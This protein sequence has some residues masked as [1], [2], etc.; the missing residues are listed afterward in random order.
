MKRLLLLSA[1]ALTLTGCMGS[2]Q[3]RSNATALS[4][5]ATIQ[6]ASDSQPTQTDLAMSCREIDGE[7][8]R[9][10]ARSE[11]LERTARAQERKG[12]LARGA[13]STGLAALTFGGITNAG[14]VSEIQN[15][16]TAST[17]ANTAASATMG[18]SGPDART[19]NETLAIFE[20]TSLL[21]RT[22]LQKGC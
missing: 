17:V 21:E 19:T 15:V 8:N 7:L 10:Y 3:T 9:L 14:S 13:V 22:K 11:E 16:H 4:G 1:A 5:L 2:S 12:A 6:R 18:N 20:R